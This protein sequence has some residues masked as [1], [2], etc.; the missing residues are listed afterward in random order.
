MQ[1]STLTTAFV[2]IGATM[3]RIPMFAKPSSISHRTG[4]SLP[5]ITNVAVHRPIGKRAG[6][7][8]SLNQAFVT[9]PAIA[10]GQVLYAPAKGRS[11]ADGDDRPTVTVTVGGCSVE[12]VTQ[13]ISAGTVTH[14]VTPY[15]Q[16]QLTHTDNPVP[17]P[18]PVKGTVMNHLAGL[19]WQYVSLSP[20][21]T[22]HICRR[23]HH[24]LPFP[25]PP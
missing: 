6:T 25:F 3:A 14:Q 22:P 20:S 23:Y 18:T 15:A 11:P 1:F 4:A 13:T 8:T 24:A 9:Q 16:G 12:I 17:A 21:S 7:I 2:L 5:L 10:P 19:P